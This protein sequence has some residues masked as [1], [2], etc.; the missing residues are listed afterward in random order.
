MEEDYKEECGVVGIS[1]KKDIDE[2]SIGGAANIA[3]RMLGS[4][5]H[6][7]QLSAG[8]LSYNGNRK[9]SLNTFR[10]K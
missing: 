8:I 5:Q 3:Y 9:K 1:L 4:L 7:G 6:R 10:K 2:Y